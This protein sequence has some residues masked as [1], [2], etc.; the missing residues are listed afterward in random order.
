MDRAHLVGRPQTGG[1]ADAPRDAPRPPPPEDG[2]ARRGTGRPA[3]PATRGALGGGPPRSRRA[4][5]AGTPPPGTWGATAPPR[6]WG[7]PPPGAPRR[8]SR[9]AGACAGK[10]CPPVPPAARTNVP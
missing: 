3:S 1:F 6:G 8:P 10:R 5:P 7:T 4:R 2:G 9:G